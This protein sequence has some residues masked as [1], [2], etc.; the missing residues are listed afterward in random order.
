MKKSV[1]GE[2]PVNLYIHTTRAF[3][4]SHE[5]VNFLE[6][7]PVGPLDDLVQTYRVHPFDRI[8]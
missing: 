5:L 7:S 3:L 8:G 1:W 2:K 6:Y 4:S